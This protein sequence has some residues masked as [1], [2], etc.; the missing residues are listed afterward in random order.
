MIK[1]FYTIICFLLC[2]S[3][4]RYDTLTASLN[5][6]ESIVESYPDSSLSI[7]KGINIS[8]IHSNKHKARY[9]LLLSIV[10]D[11]NYIDVESDSI[12]TPALKY[13]LRTGDADKKLKVLYYRGIVERN[14]GNHEAAMNWY[15]QADRFSM[16]ATDK[17]MVGRLYT[18]MMISYNRVYD[19]EASIDMA[20]K[21]CDSYHKACDTTRYI[22]AVLNLTS[23][24]IQVNDTLKAMRNIQS[25]YRYRF[26]MNK[27][28]LLNL[29]LK[30]MALSQDITKYTLENLY[31]FLKSENIDCKYVN[32]L[33]VTGKYCDSGDF[34]SANKAIE[35]Y[36]KFNDSLD[37]LYYLY[38]ANICEYFCKYKEAAES[39]R[40]YNTLSDDS[41]ISIFRDDTKF[42]EERYRSELKNVRL[43]LMLVIAA[44]ATCLIALLCFIIIVYLRKVQKEKQADRMKMIS[45]LNEMEKEKNAF[46]QMYSAAIEEQKRLKKARRDTVLGKNVRLLVDKRLSV[47]NRFVVANISGMYSK[48]AF[49]EL[50]ELMEDRNYF[51][52]STR[53]SFIIA[54]P[55]FLMFLKQYDL[56]DWE[57]ACCCM[58]CIGLNGNE[59]SDYLKRKSYYNDSSIIRKKLGLDRKISINSFLRKK[60]RELDNGE[61]KF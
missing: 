46:E 13:Y 32:W 7:L 38:N 4:S 35:Q 22:S 61:S 58:Y 55:Q 19:I 60:L 51:L 26:K 14:R 31:V 52:E 11:K 47:L 49:E 53:M 56:S 6:V 25:L 12:I 34:H 2:L 48:E 24:Y 40:I 33:M 3:C 54:H 57:I 45:M 29:Y 42:I 9:S 30:Q 21:A 41:D 39:Y 27:Q 37:D 8:S 10:N 5:E 50:S 59:I 18:A 44:L 15:V 1:I 20:Q 36:R 28:Q 17:V 43:H 23:S 16:M